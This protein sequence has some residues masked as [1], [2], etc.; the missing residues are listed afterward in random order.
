VTRFALAAAAAISL[1]MGA[2]AFAQDAAPA[3]PAA[4]PAPAPAP[5]TTE[6][7]PAAVPAP[8]TDP[9]KG[10]IYFFRPFIL[11]G[12]IYTYHVVEVGDDGKPAKGAPHLADLPSGGAVIVDIEP[13][14]HSFNIT[15]PMAVNKDEDRLRMEVEAGE[16]YYVE[17]VY[18]MGLVTGGFKLVPADQNTFATSKVKFKADKKK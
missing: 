6:T 4:A 2:S 11:S 16:T 14:I 1:M 13:G 8:G 18:R 9:T 7:P 12:A 17:Q 15:G 5:A 10:H 3:A